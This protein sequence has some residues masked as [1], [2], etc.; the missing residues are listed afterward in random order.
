M[1]FR[2]LLVFLS[3]IGVLATAGC[4]PRF[5]ANFEAVISLSP[6]L[7]G[8]TPSEA[9]VAEEL[10]ARI[11]ILPIEAQVDPGAPD[12]ARI[13][14]RLLAPDQQT[15]LAQL[16]ALCHSGEL[17]VRAVHDQTVYLS[18]AIQT[19]PG[20]MPPDHELLSYSITI[21][22][23]TRSEDLV[24]STLDIITGDDVK[25]AEPEN[26]TEG[27]IHVSLTPEGGK[28]LIQATKSMQKGRSRLA[29]L[30]DGLIIS[31]PVVGNVLSAEFALEGFNSF[32][33][34]QTVAAAPH[35][36]LSAKVL[37]ESLNPLAPAALK[38]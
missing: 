27:V 1:R 19:D 21:G 20:K 38:P 15:A 5:R 10:R 22:N 18:S 35:Q 24:V 6:E 13:S 2:R 36:P 16:D 17:S 8:A 37:I 34:A 32:E 31:A 25:T 29:I 7:S 12:D 23:Q 30:Y 9:T 28:K 4:E 3:G 14:I 33:E 11:G 26:T